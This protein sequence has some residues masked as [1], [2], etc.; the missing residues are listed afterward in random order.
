MDAAERAGL[1]ARVVPAADLL[2]EAVRTATKIASL[3]RPVTM[4]I[5]E[6]MNRAYEISRTDTLETDEGLL[7]NVGPSTPPS[8]CTINGK[9]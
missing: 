3:S 1:V 5:E 9:G 8:P 7:S 4:M 6:C 2:D